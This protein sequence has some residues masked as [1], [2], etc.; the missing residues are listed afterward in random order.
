MNFG[1]LIAAAASNEFATFGGFTETR[2]PL[3]SRIGVYFD[4]LD[5]T[6]D[7]GDT[8]IAWSAAF[9][10]FMVR[11]A[12]AGHHFPYHMLHSVYVHHLIRNKVLGVGVFRGYA[13]T[14][15]LRPRL[16]DI[17]ATNRQNKP[18]ITYAY[19]SANKSFF[20]HCDILTEVAADGTITAVGGNIGPDGRGRIARTTFRKAD[21][22]WRNTHNANHQVYCLVRATGWPSASEPAP[23][24]DYVPM[25]LP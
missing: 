3:K 23:D 17:V 16:G 6:Y 1:D 13:P 4:A 18:P 7:G 12:G 15:L 5:E 24:F 11:L 10:S 21:G 25:A 14:E 19:A 9:I 22:M 2:E 20:S 8:E